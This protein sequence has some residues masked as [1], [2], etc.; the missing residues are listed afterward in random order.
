M[1]LSRRNLLAGLAALPL[2]PGAGWGQGPDR[3]PPARPALSAGR[4][5][6]SAGLP[7]TVAF[8][9]LDDPTRP[10]ADA[11]QVAAPMMPASTLKAVTA[12]YALSRLGLCSDRVRLPLVGLT[13]ATK[14]QIDAAMEHA[15]LI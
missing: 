9:L 4:I 12:L 13:D 8:A 6:A 1:M 15:G 14:A 10:L 3:R 11:A 5:V 2:A 7:G